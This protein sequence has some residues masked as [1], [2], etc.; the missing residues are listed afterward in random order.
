M[1]KIHNS[2]FNYMSS[3]Q[4]VS[5]PSAEASKNTPIETA[6]DASDSNVAKTPADKVSDSEEVYTDWKPQINDGKLSLDPDN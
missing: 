2:D 5:T 1:K 6:Q 4:V 3:G